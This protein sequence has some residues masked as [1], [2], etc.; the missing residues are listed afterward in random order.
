MKKNIV[1]ITLLSLAF[2]ASA[3][4]ED[5]FQFGGFANMNR[6]GVI[7]PHTSIDPTIQTIEGFATN[8]LP[9]VGYQFG[10]LT[11]YAFSDVSKLQFGIGLMQTGST[12]GQ[13]S[14]GNTTRD[15]ASFESQTI[16]Q[17]LML[18]IL[19]KRNFSPKSPFYIVG[20][21][22]P[23]LKINRNNKS[24]INFADGTQQVTTVNSSFGGTSGV[25]INPSLGIGYEKKI[26]KD[27][28]LYLQP[29][30]DINAFQLLELFGN[31]RY[32]TIGL[33]VGVLS[34]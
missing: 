28:Y 11:Q 22:T 27:N 24:I 1:F 32:Y 18:P 30:I 29:N 8:N 3:Q 4:K 23:L 33:T 34:K 9:T 10:F 31:K 21:L 19:Y 16:N 13:F 14:I 15:I 26:F 6:C 20:G 7:I 17:D 25:N 12:T 5:N 2:C